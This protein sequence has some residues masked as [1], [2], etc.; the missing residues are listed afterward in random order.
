MNPLNSQ[1]SILN[2]QLITAFLLLIASCTFS[3]KQNDR[4]AVE[5]A[6][7]SIDSLFVPTGNMELDSLLQLAA[8]T[9]HDINL[10]RLYNQIAK[11]Y[12]TSDIEKSREYRFK[13]GEL[14]ERL[15]CDE[16]RIYLASRT[17]FSLAQH[18]G[19][20][21]SAIV[22]YKQGLKFAERDNND[23][24]MCKFNYCIGGWFAIDYWYETGLSYLLKALTIAEQNNYQDMIGQIYAQ[25]CGAYSGLGDAEKAIE[26]GK[27]G[28]DISLPSDL[29]L[30]LCNLG[31]AYFSATQYDKSAACF[32]EALR[33]CE[34][35]NNI[36]T[37]TEAYQK[38]GFIALHQFDLD[39]AE[40]Y[41]NKSLPIAEEF[42]H[43]R[44]ICYINLTAGY[45]ELY[46]GN[47]KKAEEHAMKALQTAIDLDLLLEK[48]QNYNLLANISL[49]RHDFKRSQL[50]GFISDSI[51][52]VYRSEFAVRSASELA[53]KYET[54][55]KELEIEN[56]K[57]IIKSQNLQRG[58]LVG[59]IALSL[60]IL[61]L[62]WY[63][64]RLRI[65]RNRALTERND[66]LAEMNATKDKFFNI[67]SHDI[68]NP[69]ITQRD[70]MKLLV[71]NAFQWDADTLDRFYNG[72]LETAESNV[73]LIY[74]LLG[75]AQ[76]Q[77]GR[78][79]FRPA[80][81][82]LA[83]CLRSEISLIRN[84]AEKKNIRFTANIP[85][86]AD[87]TGDSNMI[88]TVV[89]NLLTNAV[90]FTSTSGEVSLSVSLTSSK[91]CTIS[92][93]DTGTGM[94]EDQINN[95]FRLDSARSSRGT[96]GE[97]GSGLGLIVCKELLEKHGATLHVESE[98]GRGSRFWF[99][100]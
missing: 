26:Y 9:Q 15:D 33:A 80:T 69:A 18:E 77:T 61:A 56:Q 2:S 1:F 46:R 11:I 29:P 47:F 84:M 39:K 14:S 90:K 28:V 71:D 72:L 27:K 95:L 63:M 53:A 78:M 5:S 89:R 52:Q 96:A 32:E 66:T 59:G 25:I 98:V 100:I 16:G 20:I 23:L 88:A 17:A 7:V 83:A 13:L 8:V 35:H 81:F 67:I 36:Y 79:V 99:N 49:A 64:L 38:L 91:T 94:N 34:L 48:S 42:G 50:L 93:T 97:Q 37:T 62:L 76:L 85:A 24:W 40:M 82:N 68:K 30:S 73:E 70:A 21:D 51:N 6:A 65:R 54:E 45:I 58:L 87:V 57:Q 3:C 12:E 55:K 10:V 31:H 41:N 86:D 92:I 60:V 74:N 44:L 19:L 22:V 4:Q 43:T 75:W